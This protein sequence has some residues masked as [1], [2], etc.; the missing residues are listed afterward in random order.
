MCVHVL[1]VS[2][3]GG[4]APF[5]FA[6]IYTS[7]FTIFPIHMH[8]CMQHSTLTFTSRLNHIQK[9]A[10]TRETVPEETWCVFSVLYCGATVSCCEESWGECSHIYMCLLSIAVALPYSSYYPGKESVRTSAHLVRVLYVNDLTYCRS[11]TWKDSFL[12]KNLSH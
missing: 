1:S 9:E 4:G 2:V 8:R 3:Y 12:Y 10:S 7:I 6:E 11:R 5:S